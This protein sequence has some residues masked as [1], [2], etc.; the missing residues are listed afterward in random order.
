MIQHVV[1]SA[2]RSHATGVFVAT[3]HREVFDRVQDFGGQAVMTGGHHVSGSDRIAEACEIL[4]F[5]DDML[6]VNVQGDEPLI[7]PCVIDQV[8]T[9]LADCAAASMATLCTPIRSMQEF[10]DPGAVKVVQ[11]ANGFARYFSRAPIP[12]KRGSDNAALEPGG[13]SAARRHL[14]IYAYRSGYIQRFSA[15]QA[16][17]LELIE[18]LEQLRALWHGEQIIC[19]IA[20]QEP[21]PGVDSAAD[22][23]RV[24][25]FLTG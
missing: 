19:A 6:V 23:E 10:T 24:R 13:F 15:R 25:A 14:G 7:P 9:L 16:C 21:L 3:D 2:G 11:D 1:E 18:Q 12:W 22:L 5:S 8:A 4:G 17:E 20:E